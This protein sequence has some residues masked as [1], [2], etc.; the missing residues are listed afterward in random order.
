MESAPSANYS[1]KIKSDNKTYDL[2]FAIKSDKLD[3]SIS[4]NSSISLSFN[5]AFT[6]DELLKLNRYFRQFDT[7]LE[8][9]NFIVDLENIEELI[10]IKVENKFIN[11]KISIP[12]VLKNKA[13]N[14]IIFVLPAVQ[15]KESE[16][17]VK[18]CQ[19]VEKINILEKKI[20]YIFLCIGKTEE[21]FKT[22]EE[23]YEKL[24]QTLKH[25]SNVCESRIVSPEDFATVQ[26]GIKEKLNK[27][28]KGAKLLYR[29]SR[30]GDKNQ[31]H[32]KCDGIENTV[33]FVKAKNG[34]KFGGFANKAFNSSN[35]YISDPKCFVFSLLHKECY[36]YN[37][38]GY[39]I[40]GSSS[41]GPLWGSGSSH[42]LYLASGCLNNTAS[43]TGQSSFDY[44]GKSNALS[45]SSNFQAEDYETYQLILE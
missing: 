22:Y 34:R 37:N 41:Y 27:T 44:K 36:Y 28:I 9:Y 26:I 30:D 5:A 16:L 13:N 1:L 6:F 12:S 3:I 42:D 43:T 20:N 11:L 19:E 4:N 39:M 15:I 8:I 29:A 40:Y 45:G 24:P 10:D 18:L 2:K 25:L 35:Q 23:A 14:E 31:F 21:D 38:N 7:I 33:T 32:S 17:I